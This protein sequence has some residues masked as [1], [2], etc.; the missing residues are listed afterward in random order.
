[1][2]VKFPSNWKSI[3]GEC[4]DANGHMTPISSE[5]CLQMKGLTSK[6]IGEGLS[7]LSS[8]DNPQ[9]PPNALQFS[10]LCKS[11]NF[12]NIFDEILTY[13]QNPIGHEFVWKSDFAYTV[14]RKMNIR[15]GNKETPQQLYA[16]AERLYLTLSQNE[17][18]DLPMLTITEKLPS[19]DPGKFER[20][21][22]QAKMARIINCVDINLWNNNAI[23]KLFTKLE[24]QKLMANQTGLLSCFIKKEINKR[25]ERC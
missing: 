10:K 6:Q 9:F 8:I 5:W 16:R 17:L 12:E 3:M 14:Y 21:K 23:K 2:A 22:F 13:M 25:V 19:P 1:M 24:T 7:K 11:G 18:I 15:I 4:A 20:R